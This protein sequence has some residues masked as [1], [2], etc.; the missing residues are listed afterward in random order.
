MG[1]NRTTI[2][3]P[4]TH[5]C[6]TPR[7]IGRDQLQWAQP[8]LA[9]NCRGFL[10]VACHH[11]ALSGD[12]DWSLLPTPRPLTPPSIQP[13]IYS[14]SLPA[15]PLVSKP[16]HLLLLPQPV[17]GAF[18]GVQLSYVYF[19]LNARLHTHFYMLCEPFPPIFAV[20]MYRRLDPPPP[21]P[22]P[23]RYIRN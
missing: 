2:G 3:R 20:E 8:M 21:P 7:T 15:R 4:T 23:S 17:C 18:D 1:P 9:T 11:G 12:M 22:R 16:S 5:P 10:G 6:G 13:H 19:L 14:F